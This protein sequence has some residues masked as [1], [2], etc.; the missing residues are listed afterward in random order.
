M[1]PMA[2][3]PAGALGLAQFMPGTWRE[4]KMKIGMVNVSPFD[5]EASIQAGAFYMNYLRD[6]WYW[7]RPE[8]DRH[9][10]ALASYNAGLGSLLLAQ[11]KANNATD[12]KPIVAC[13]SDITGSKAKETKVYVRRIWGYFIDQI[14]GGE[15]DRSTRS[16]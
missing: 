12:Y 10:L 15:H 1:N 2:V 3:S 11:K 8:A 7:R 6:Q 16:F 9:A 14:L 13:L 4:V 5:A